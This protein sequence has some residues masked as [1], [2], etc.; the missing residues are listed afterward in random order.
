MKNPNRKYG[1]KPQV[2]DHRDKKYGYTFSKQDLPRYVDYRH[3]CT[4][5]EDQGQT[6]SCTGHGTTSAME[7]RFNLATREGKTVFKDSLFLSRMFVYYNA[8]KQSIFGRVYDQGA[9]IRDAVKGA[10]K[11]GVCLE[12]VYPFAIADINKKP[13]SA[14]FLNA[15]KHKLQEYLAVENLEELKLS[16]ANEHPVVFGFTV[17]PSFELESTLK[18]GIVPFPSQ[19]EKP[20]GGHCVYACGYDDQNQWVICGNS[21][22]ETWGDKGFFYLPYSF[23]EK[24]LASDM[25]SIV[26]IGE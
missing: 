16:L 3:L 10:F 23:F 8:R 1:W 15:P 17:Y 18:T 6:N 4:V 7:L 19:D 25:W 2:P 26:T 21:Y 12:E 24:G 9:F 14:A 22:G 20:I 13:T 5:I 11:I